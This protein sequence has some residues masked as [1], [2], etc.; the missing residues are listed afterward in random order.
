MKKTHLLTKPTR[1]QDINFDDFDEGVDAR[2]AER[3]EKSRIRSY[4][5]LRHPEA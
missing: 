2:W 4:R 1:I 5:K 3:V